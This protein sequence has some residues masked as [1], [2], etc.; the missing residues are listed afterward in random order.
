M[1]PEVQFLSLFSRSVLIR[2]HNALEHSQ[3]LQCPDGFAAARAV[4]DDQRGGAM[5]GSH[6]GRNF[7]HL[8]GGNYA[9]LGAGPIRANY[10]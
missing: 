1:L 6:S 3:T 9:L 7:T 2:P 8:G 5:A 10:R 4:A